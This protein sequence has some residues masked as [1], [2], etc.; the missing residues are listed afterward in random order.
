LE[1][2]KRFPLLYNAIY[3][4]FQYLL[5]FA[6][7]ALD[8]SFLDVPKF[9]F[10]IV[11]F[12]R[13]SAFP[14]CFPLNL[15][16]YNFPGIRVTSTFNIYFKLIGQLPLR[17]TVNVRGA[18]PVFALSSNSHNSVSSSSSCSLLALFLFF[19]PEQLLQFVHLLSISI[20]VM[21]SLNHRSR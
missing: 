7:L 6:C 3:Y 2:H 4:T 14:S 11:S 5:Y 20:Y 19:S 10:I 17:R 8:I 1:L 9:H 15:N 16:L 12:S 13:I 18:Y 21:L